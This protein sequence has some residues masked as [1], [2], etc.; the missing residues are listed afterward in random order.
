MGLYWGI[1]PLL[2]LY[3]TQIEMIKMKNKGLKWL[4]IF[5]VM[6]MFMLSNVYAEEEDFVD[7]DVAGSDVSNANKGFG[8]TLRNVFSPLDVVGGYTCSEQP[9]GVKIYSPSKPSIVR[10]CVTLESQPAMSMEMW[11][12]ELSTDTYGSYKGKKHFLNGDKKCWDVNYGTF[13]VIEKYYCSEGDVP[14]GNPK[15]NYIDGSHAR[16][17]EGRKSLI[18][19]IDVRNE[20]TGSATGIIEMQVRPKGLL[21]LAVTGVNTCNPDFPENVHANINIDAG[22]T[23][24]ITFRSQLPSTDGEWDLYFMARQACGGTGIEGNMFNSIK[25]ETLTVGSGEEIPSCKFYESLTSKIIKIPLP[26]FPDIDVPTG[27]PVCAPDYFKIGGIV[28][29]GLLALFIIT[30]R[31][32]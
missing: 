4:G 26:F 18:A 31:R 2:F 11:E 30:R 28:L 14:V 29:I 21:P 15:L 6:L 5:L 27:E 20:G 25:T 12:Y 1:F 32:K 10:Y 22:S 24:R 9:D 16:W 13:Y 3:L 7:T 19:T 17:I 23:E 8:Y